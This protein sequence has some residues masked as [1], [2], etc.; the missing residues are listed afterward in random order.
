MIIIPYLNYTPKIDPSVTGQRWTVVIGRA[1]GGARTQ[2][3]ALVKLRGDGLGIDIGPDC[4]FGDYS[5]VH[6][7]DSVYGSSA[8]ARVTVGLLG[9]VLACAIGDVCFI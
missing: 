5:T 1:Q 3:G 6:I 4:W 7:A 8:G 2:L 9:L